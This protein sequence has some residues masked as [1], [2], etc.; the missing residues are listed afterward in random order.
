MYDW[1]LTPAKLPAV[2]LSDHAAVL[3]QASN[4]S[5]YRPGTDIVVSCRICDHN[6]KVLVAHELANINWSA[7]VPNGVMRRHADSF[8]SLIHI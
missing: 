2:G 5:N 6:S 3:L 4:N 7:F 1:Y 8:L